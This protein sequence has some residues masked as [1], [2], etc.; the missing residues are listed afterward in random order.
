MCSSVWYAVHGDKVLLWW[1]VGCHGALQD[2]EAAVRGKW[3]WLLVVWKAS[4]ARVGG[5][6][7]VAC[8]YVQ[9]Y[10]PPVLWSLHPQR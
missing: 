6:I 2:H 4:R 8:D 10:G 5:E 9:D 3:S 7:I 1:T